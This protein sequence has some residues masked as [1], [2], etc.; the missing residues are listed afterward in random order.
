MRQFAI[1]IIFDFL[2]FFSYTIYMKKTVL[3]LLVIVLTITM[4]AISCASTKNSEEIDTEA[5]TSSETPQ[6]DAALIETKWILTQVYNPDNI[7]VPDFSEMEL[8]FSNEEEISGYGGSNIF[9]GQYV[10]D[11]NK[12]KLAPLGSTRMSTPFD[13]FEMHYM[14][15][16]KTLKTYSINSDILSIYG[17]DL[18]IPIM[19]F[20]AYSNM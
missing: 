7:S 2:I 4:T 19:E 20:K 14:S 16:F 18:N 8:V 11:K 5:G 6:N 13:M 1:S 10:A 15:L 3:Y 12:I 17:E 9:F